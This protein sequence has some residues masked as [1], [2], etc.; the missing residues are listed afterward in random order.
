M[1]GRNMV[2]SSYDLTNQFSSQSGDANEKSVLEPLVVCGPSGVGK[3]TIIDRYMDEYNG[4]ERFQFT[5]SH[6]TRQ[7]R[8]GELPGFHYHFVTHAEMQRLLDEEAFLE[9][10]SVHGNWY[11]TSWM[12]IGAVQQTG[13]RALLDIDVQ[14][15][16]RIKEIASESS[17]TRLDPK[18]IFIA[19]PSVEVL[20]E[21]LIG[22]AS[23][24][25]ESLKRRVA[26]AE[27]E[28]TY[29]L[30]EGN[31]DAI[32]INDDLAQAVADFDAAIDRLYRQD[33]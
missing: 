15:V 22:R 26:N 6:T 13:R 33:L 9:S 24:S 28:L 4:S 19:P 27:A 10:A 25:E 31:F 11:G 7:P 3:G 23:E 14:G 29:G 20:R 32:V 2:V 30:A 21:R 12:A 18:Y 1:M 16:Q 17:P 8:E 5:T